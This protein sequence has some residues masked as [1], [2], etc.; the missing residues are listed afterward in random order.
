MIRCGSGGRV[1]AAWQTQTSKFRAL[2]TAKN[3]CLGDCLMTGSIQKHN[4]KLAVIF[5][6]VANSAF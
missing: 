1:T 6:I 3:I 2:K 4:K 5:S